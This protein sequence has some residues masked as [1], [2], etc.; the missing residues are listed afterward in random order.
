[1]STKVIAVIGLIIS[2]ASL[3]VSWMQLQVMRQQVA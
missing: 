3:L 2:A 1:V